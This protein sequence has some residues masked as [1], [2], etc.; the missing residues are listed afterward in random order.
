MLMLF[1]GI[2]LCSPTVMAWGPLTHAYIAAT[3]IPEAPPQALF[4]A[5]AADMNAIC[6]RKDIGNVLKKLTHSQASLVAST[7]FQLGLETHNADW[8]ADS[9]AHAYFSNPDAKPYPYTIFRQ[10]SEEMDISI[11][12]SED[13]MEAVMDYVIG[14]DLGSEFLKDIS[15]AINAVGPVEE[16]AFVHAFTEPLCMSVEDLSPARAERIIRSVFR[17]DRL[18]LRILISFMA[19][20]E[21]FR[22]EIGI[23]LL[24]D[25]F[26]MDTEKM[27]RCIKRGIELCS[28]WRTQLD[29]ISDAITHQLQQ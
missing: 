9:Y 17:L 14:R 12:T 24:A 22:F 28:D 16:Q 29:A 13:I 5:M 23:P 25:N 6:G 10:L 8:G 4:G 27:E 3:V 11:H 21:D 2:F 18:L 1:G 15:A 26:D 20:P 7:P 19:L